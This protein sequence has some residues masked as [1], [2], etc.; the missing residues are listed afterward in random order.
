M[1][2]NK[3]RQQMTMILFQDN[4]LVNEINMIMVSKSRH[5]LKW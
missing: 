5:S 3:Y 2:E 1:S 4:D